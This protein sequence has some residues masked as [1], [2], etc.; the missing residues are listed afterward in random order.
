MALRSWTAR[1]VAGAVAAAALATSSQAATYIFD[2]H[3]IRRAG[4]VGP[5]RGDFIQRWTFE[6]QVSG[7]SFE[8]PGSSLRFERANAPTTRT[9]S[10]FESLINGISGLTLPDA[11]FNALKAHI[12]GFGAPPSSTYSIDFAAAA[13]T[14]V[15]SGPIRILRTSSLTMSAMG[16]QPNNFDPLDQYGVRDL[17]LH[18][19]PLSWTLMGRT[20]VLRDGVTLFDTRLAYVGSA[21]LIGFE[22]TPLSGPGPGPSAAPEPATWALLLSGFG[23][24]GA[25][26]RRRAARARPA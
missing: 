6:P 7:S 21:T 3:A 4:T 19:G 14:T 2:I 20:Q 26:L 5:A 1:L 13:S 18:A 9:S 8:G 16:G 10:T 15:D 22:P 17:L 24:A 11:G 23:L 12:A 25:R